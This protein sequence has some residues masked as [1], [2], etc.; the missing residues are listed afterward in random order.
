MLKIRFNSQTKILTGWTD[1]KEE[2]DLLTAREGENIAIFDIAK[3]ITHSEDYEYYAFKNGELTDSGK[4]EPIPVR[5]LAKEVDNLKA[6]I[7]KLEKG[8]TGI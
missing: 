7:E 2:F 4:P 3:P 5:D 6:R 1:R 8:Q